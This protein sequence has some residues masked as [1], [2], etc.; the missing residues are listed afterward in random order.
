MKESTT[1]VRLVQAPVHTKMEMIAVSS[2][3]PSET[4]PR[5]R[6]NEAALA[7]LAESVRTKGVLQPVLV[8]PFPWRWSW[9]AG[10]IHHKGEFQ[11]V[12]LKGKG[13]ELLTR[14]SGPIFSIQ[15]AAEKEAAARQAKLP[16]FELV[17]GE[18]RYRAAKIAGL[19]AIPALISDL[20]DKAA[21]EVQI[22]ENLQREDLEPLEEAVGYQVLISEH[23][24]SVDHLAETLKK[25]R[26]YV[27]AMLKLCGLPKAAKVALEEGLI[28]KSTAELIARLPND[29]LREKFAAEVLKPEWDESLMSLRKAKDLQERSYMVELKGAPFP[30]QDADLLPAAGPCAT[31][32]KLAGNARDLF[33]DG[34][35]DMC[36]DPACFGQ[37]KTAHF[38][39]LKE[40]AEAQGL[41]VLDMKASNKLFSSWSSSLQTGDYLDLAEVC[42]RD[43]KK[44]P[45]SYKQ[46][47]EGSD[48]KPV[49]AFDRKGKERKLVPRPAAEKFL[50]E[51]HKIEL[52]YVDRGNNQARYEAEERKRRE[53]TAIRMLARNK[54]AEAV[55]AYKWKCDITTLRLLV[56]NLLHSSSYHLEG[57]AAARLPKG[58][59]KSRAVS[60]DQV[61]NW[62]AAEMLGAKA[63]S[64]IVA[65]GLQITVFSFL[66]S[67]AQG[68]EHNKTDRA[69]VE[70]VL[71]SIGL[72]LETVV[73]EAR[74]ELAGAGATKVK[75]PAKK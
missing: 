8:R 14:Y 70:R 30:Q 72:Q 58:V 65:V 36:T 22:I 51:Q 41:E 63:E 35:S 20:D 67:W 50:K 3:A 61:M 45:R 71:R 19:A 46:L 43:K 68:Y 33:P 16:E 38:K 7:E 2:I 40:R 9:E 21:L 47:L 37:K 25:S 53:L 11:V 6:F 17:A 48:I 31:C 13:P 57:L 62:L 18:R 69:F 75:R 29:K 23:K 73:N 12:Q 54:I 24:Y 49:I 28:P 5:K 42:H 52:G 64:D 60:G 39:R 27:Y 32:P 59:Q 4:N 74:L 44:K 26:S 10:A 34:R 56:P 55:R 1:T 66:Q 15:E